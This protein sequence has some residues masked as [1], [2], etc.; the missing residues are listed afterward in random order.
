MLL[1]VYVLNI[2]SLVQSSTC[3]WDASVDSHLTV[4]WENQHLHC[5][6][7]LYAVAL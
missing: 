2:Y 6:V 1:V 3:F 4:R 5:V 7:V